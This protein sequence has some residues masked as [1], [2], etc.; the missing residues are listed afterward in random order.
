MSH[1]TFR[2]AIGADHGAVDLKNAVAAHL[3]KVGH[4]VTDFGTQGHES[5]D[6]PD[7][8]NLVARNV[9]DGT[10]DFGILGCTS[11]VGMSIAANRHK[12]VRAANVRTVEETETTRLHNDANILCLGAKTVDEA[13]AIAMVDAFLATGFEGGR[14]ESR[15]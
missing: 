3:K 11:G 6:Y 13:T 10:Y 7:F 9:G 15:V 8:A 14:H 1:P 4:E 2:I 5:V 12:H